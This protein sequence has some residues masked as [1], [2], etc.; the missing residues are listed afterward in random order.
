MAFRE[1]EESRQVTVGIDGFSAV[2]S[3]TVED[4]DTEIQAI[5]HSGIP[6]VR[7][8]HPERTGAIVMNV[9]G[10]PIGPRVF[11]VMVQYGVPEPSQSFQPE[12]PGAT[13]LIELGSSSTVLTTSRDI[14]TGEAIILEHTYVETLATGDVDRRTERQGAEVEYEAAQ[15]LLVQRRQELYPPVEK[16][17]IYGNTVNRFRIWGFAPE[18]LLCLP[19]TAT[20]SDG[21]ASWTVTYQFQAA[22]TW[23]AEAR[24]RDKTTGKPPVDLVRGVGIKDVTVFKRADFSDLGLAFPGFR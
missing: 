12:T 18:T 22:D 4:V 3:F 19:I 5:E 2:R 10:K 11:R 24:F 7:D 9:T 20:S 8:S 1:V 23:K 17:R 15:M 21:G 14:E 13:G 16:A 6:R